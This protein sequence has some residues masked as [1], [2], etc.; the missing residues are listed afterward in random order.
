MVFFWLTLDV[1][2]GKA[3]V[4]K[5][6]REAWLDHERRCASVPRWHKPYLLL[7]GLS[8]NISDIEAEAKLHKNVTI[9]IIPK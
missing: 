6:E 1:Y 4:H 8:V 3:W 5:T 9:E 2:A 7:R